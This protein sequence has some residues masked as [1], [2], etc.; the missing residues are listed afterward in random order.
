MISNWCSS[1]DSKLFLLYLSDSEIN[2]MKIIFKTIKR[3]SAFVLILLVLGVVLIYAT[4]NQYI[5]RGVKLT[6]L[7]GKKTANIDDRL[8]FDTREIATGK[9][10]EWSLSEHY[11]EIPLTDTLLQELEAHHGFFARVIGRFFGSVVYRG[12]FVFHDSRLR[13][14]RKLLLSSEPNCQSLLRKRHYRANFE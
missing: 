6:Y 9:I 11:N 1:I 7:K 5:F 13:L 12:R 10:Q 8:D 14:E 4:D 2:P 3:L